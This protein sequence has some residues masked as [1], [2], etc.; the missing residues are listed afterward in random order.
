[1]RRN[2]LASVLA[3]AAAAGLSFAQ[4]QS[5]TRAGADHSTSVSKQG[6]QLDIA[7][8]TSLTAELQNTLDVSKA[9]VG[10][11]VILKTTE[12]IKSNGETIA[13]RGSRLVGHVAEVTK[14]GKSSAASSVTIIFDQLESGSLSTP[15]SAT[16]DSITQVA[17]RARVGD[18]GASA[19]ASGRSSTSARSTSSSSSGGL[20]G[21]VTGAVGSTV[22]GVAGA[23]GDVVGSTTDTVGGTV[24]GAGQ[25]LGQIQIT[26]SAGVS[27]EG[28]STLSLTGG[29][30]RL[31]KGTAFKL[32]LNESANVGNNQ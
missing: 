1:M 15:I 20:L 19:D 28:G 22:G 16:I 9:R 17:G 23:A 6:K 13:K 7:S 24:R 14:R 29:N 25:T 5:N 27:A 3:L 12:A 31:E 18:D 11:K 30:L 21:G 26:Q 10:D 8:G 32:T 4:T 2:F